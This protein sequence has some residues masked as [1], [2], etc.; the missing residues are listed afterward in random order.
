MNKYIHGYIL[1][2]IILLCMYIVLNIFNGV[3]QPI[4]ISYLIYSIFNPLISILYNRFNINI[5]FSAICALVICYSFILAIIVYVIPIAKYIFEYVISHSPILTEL[6][7]SSSNKHLDAFVNS[8]VDYIQVMLRQIITESGRTLYSSMSYCLISPLIAFHMMIKKR[9]I[10]YMLSRL[11]NIYE[12]LIYIHYYWRQY[13]TCQAYLC[14]IMAF[15][16]SFA[17]YLASIPYYIQLGLLIGLISFIPYM[18]FIIGFII[19][20]IVSM[21]HDISSIYLL[22]FIFGIGQIIENIILVPILM[23]NAISMGPITIIITM[24]TANCLL[25]FT[26]AILAL[27]IICCIQGIW[28]WWDLTR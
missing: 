25:G 8:I 27:P 21:N 2:L 1:I 23:S 26:G 4:M 7:S 13:I 6:L 17:M 9:K 12:I 14:L 19:S 5:F 16:Y 28:K 24:L 20:A 15:Y 18:G 3:W 10:K 11:G 22:F